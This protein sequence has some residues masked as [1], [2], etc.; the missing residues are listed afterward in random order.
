MSYCLSCSGK[1]ADDDNQAIYDCHSC[2][3]EER[4]AVLEAK[5][6]EAQAETVSFKTKAE[7][8]VKKVFNSFRCRHCGSYNALFHAHDCPVKFEE[9]LQIPSTAPHPS[10]AEVYRLQVERDALKTTLEQVRVGLQAWQIRL[11]FV[12]HPNE[13][14]DWSEPIRLTELIALNA[15]KE[16]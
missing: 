14:R 8:F 6:A 3:H 1:V 7:D 13:P 9:F 16:A 10:D 4:I 12:G 11:A 15:G 5:L 2:G